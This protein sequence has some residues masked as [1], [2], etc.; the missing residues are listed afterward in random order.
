MLTKGTRPTPVTG[1]GAA[2][3]VGV[4]KTGSVPGFTASFPDANCSAGEL[5]PNR[6]CI[7]ILSGVFFSTNPWQPPRPTTRAAAR[8][9]KQRFGNADMRHANH[10]C[11]IKVS[12]ESELAK[13]A[14]MQSIVNAGAKL[15]ME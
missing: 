7:P 8:T 14:W 9:R 13:E 12:I 1:P 11:R 10:P 4:L 15:C 3:T 5:A 2:A 6:L